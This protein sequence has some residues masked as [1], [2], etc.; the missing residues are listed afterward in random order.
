MRKFITNIIERVS[1]FIGRRPHVAADPM[2][3][4]VDGE[5]G[6]RIPPGRL[7][8]ALLTSAGI[9][10]NGIR[11][12]DAALAEL[13]LKSGSSRR[14][15]IKWDPSDASYIKVLD[16]A[17]PGEIKWITVQ[18]VDLPTKMS[19]A[20]YA[21]LREFARSQGIAF[22]TETERSEAL[23]RLKSHWERLAGL[24]PLRAHRIASEWDGPVAD[25]IDTLPA[26][27]DMPL[28]PESRPRARKPRKAALLK[29]KRT[30]SRKAAEAKT[31]VP[32]RISRA[33]RK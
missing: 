20:E 7:D 2:L 24:S 18:A 1:R 29:A 13:P 25:E 3:C 14:I 32:T 27:E 8:T 12:H 6:I 4:T 16:R 10:I 26:T 21:R 28:A 33:K 19:F 23:E 5:S 9:R 31:K 15:P 30:K 11:Y 22:G 17:L